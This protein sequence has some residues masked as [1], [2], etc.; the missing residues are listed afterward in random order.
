MTSRQSGCY[1]SEMPQTFADAIS[2]TRHPGVRYLWIDSL[3]ICQDDNEDWVRESARMCN[4]YS[5]AH[6]VIAVDLSSDCT[7]G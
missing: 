2:I 1:V 4:L 5:N 6:V 7:G 3:C